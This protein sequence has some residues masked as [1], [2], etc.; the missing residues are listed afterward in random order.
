MC[1]YFVREETSVCVRV[2]KGRKTIRKNEYFCEQLNFPREIQARR[3]QNCC[4]KK[5]SKT[6]IFEIEK[7]EGKKTYGL[8]ETNNKPFSFCNG[9]L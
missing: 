8:N 2:I 1:E 3:I 6:A 7:S 9:P 4:L 5:A